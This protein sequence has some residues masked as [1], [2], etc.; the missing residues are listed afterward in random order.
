MNPEPAWVAE[1]CSLPVA[2][3]QVREDAL[4]DLQVL[5]GLAPRARVIMVASGGCTVCALAASSSVESIQAVDP[6]PAQ[7]ALTRLKLDLL[8]RHHPATRLTVLGHAPMPA[9][10]RQAE[11]E[12]ILARLGLPPD[13]LGPLALTAES[14]PDHSGRYE[15][16]FLALRE[17]LQPVRVQLHELLDLEDSDAQSLRVAPN[18]RLGDALDGAFDSVM[19]LPNLVRLFGP[20]ATANPVEPFSRHF[21][22]RTRHVLA[23]QPAARNPWLWQL[24]K[25][26]FPAGVKYPWLH[27]AVPTRLPRILLTRGSMLDTLR[28]SEPASCDFVHLSN[29]LDWLSPP[30]ARETLF[31]AHRVLEPGGVVLIRQLNSTLDVPAA[32]PEFLWLPD[33]SQ[34]LHEADRSFF[35]RKIHLGR[36]E[37]SLQ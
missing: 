26:S 2:F 18:T 5:S 9:K 7:L 19:A 20:D 33:A 12:S 32:A 8:T 11:I 23:T 36:K 4:L 3:A 31:A 15:R 24:F 28:A 13:A 27:A 14:G 29:I 21:A 25:G 6:N 22:R 10:Q 1:A 16:L 30:E 37:R 35:Y 17:E 34:R